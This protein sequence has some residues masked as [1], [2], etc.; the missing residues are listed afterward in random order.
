M[1]GLGGSYKK[2]FQLPGLPQNGTVP[3]Y[4][5]CFLLIEVCLYLGHYTHADSALRQGPIAI[6]DSQDSKWE[7]LQMCSLLQERLW[8]SSSISVGMC[9]T[10]KSWPR[11][12]NPEKP[13][14]RSDCP[15]SVRTTPG[16]LSSLGPGTMDM[17]T[18]HLKQGDPKCS[19]TW[20][21]LYQASHADNFLVYN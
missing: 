3:A 21:F 1:N 4:W 15:P 19:F 10:T 11:A 16:C 7:C 5:G 18:E 6:P 20:S 12:W 14:W 13:A 9:I 2:F 8:H 17:C